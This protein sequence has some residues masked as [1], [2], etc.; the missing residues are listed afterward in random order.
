MEWEDYAG[1]GV[2]DVMAKLASRITAIDGEEGDHA[3]KTKTL[4][5]LMAIRLAIIEVK[6]QRYLEEEQAD[7]KIK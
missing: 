1:N 6:A 5:F 7:W 3:E 2:A 4:A